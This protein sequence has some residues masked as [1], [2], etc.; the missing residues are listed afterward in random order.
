ML[1]VLLLRRLQRLQPG[2]ALRPEQRVA[3]ATALPLV[4][5]LLVLA[6]LVLAAGACQLLQRHGSPVQRVCGAVRRA[7]PA[8]AAARPHLRALPA[9][10]G[11]AVELAVPGVTLLLLLLLLRMCVVCVVCVV[12]LRMLLLV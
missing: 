4:L 8:A 11:I 9:S 5:A 12:L 6:L 1:L 2:G 3:E 7:H 10:A